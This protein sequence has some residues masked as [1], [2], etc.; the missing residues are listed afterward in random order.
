MRNTVAKKLRKKS[1]AMAVTLTKVGV[2]N[3]TG[4]TYYW[5]R[6]TQRGI[7]LALKRMYKGG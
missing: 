6:N 1:I 5:E 4:L 7:Y 3:K 2:F